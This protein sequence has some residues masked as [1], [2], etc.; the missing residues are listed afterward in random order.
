MLAMFG[1][2]VPPIFARNRPLGSQ[3]RGHHEQIRLQSSWAEELPW[4]HEVFQNLNGKNC[5][6]TF[7]IGDIRAMMRGMDVDAV[8][9]PVPAVDASVA[10]HASE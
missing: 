6:P 2:P 9:I 8:R 3:A 5:A 7:T 4:I 1:R 10:K